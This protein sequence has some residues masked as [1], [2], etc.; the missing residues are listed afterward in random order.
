[1][2]GSKIM[3]CLY[4]KAKHGSV[5]MLADKISQ[6][7]VFKYTRIPYTRTWEDKNGITYYDTGKDTGFY[8]FIPEEYNYVVRFCPKGGI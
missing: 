3:G 7:N 2:K 6:K 1:M 4:F 5:I 8:F